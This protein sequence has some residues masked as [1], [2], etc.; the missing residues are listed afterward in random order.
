MLLYLGVSYKC[1]LPR[2]I[3]SAGCIFIYY[4]Y[5]CICMWV[6]SH[7]KQGYCTTR[8]YK[9]GGVLSNLFFILLRKYGT[10]AIYLVY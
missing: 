9:D 3:Q 1:G 4:A 7:M 5:Y 10:K 8:A 6:V 2:Y